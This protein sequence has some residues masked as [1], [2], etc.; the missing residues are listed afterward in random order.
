MTSSNISNKAAKMKFLEKTIQNVSA[1]LS[2]CAIE[3]KAAN[4]V[5]GLEPGHVCRL[6]QLL[7]VAAIQSKEA[8]AHNG[9][10][11]GFENEGDPSVKNSDPGGEFGGLNLNEEAVT[12]SFSQ[13]IETSQIRAG[14]QDYESARE[15]TS[16]G[17]LS[18]EAEVEPKQ[19]TKFDN[20]TKKQQ[21]IVCKVSE[22]EGL[23]LADRIALC[24]FDMLQTGAWIG[25]LISRP[26]CSQKLLQRPPFRFLHDLIMAIGRETG[27][28]M[29]IFT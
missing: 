18:G 23:S 6:L 3:A 19:S 29:E 12:S 10:V 27:F 11:S 20:F 14:S 15:A 5:A 24:N 22:F 25:Q 4:I 8:D 16:I 13:R 2:N 26:K 9:N 1:E 21:E 17:T 7:V 28:G